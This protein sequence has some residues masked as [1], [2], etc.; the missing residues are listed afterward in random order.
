MSIDT[1]IG[2]ARQVDTDFDDE[3]YDSEGQCFCEPCRNEE[4]AYWKSL[5]DAAPL[6]ERDPEEYRRQM[7]EAGRGHLL[8]PDWSK[9]L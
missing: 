8:P 5:W 6:S 1:C 7:I 2:C 3:A 9:T 4:F